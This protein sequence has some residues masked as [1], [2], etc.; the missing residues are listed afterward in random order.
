MQTLLDSY[1]CLVLLFR[2]YIRDGPIRCAGAE[3]RKCWSK[4]TLASQ[5][6]RNALSIEATTS[7]GMRWT[8]AHPS[9]TSAFG[10][11]D[12]EGRTSS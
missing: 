5:L 11:S 9:R 1:Q 3:R 12:V 6:R 10:G 7:K 4:W 2:P 8:T